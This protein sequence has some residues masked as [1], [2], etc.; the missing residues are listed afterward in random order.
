MTADT[1]VS[2]IG[3]RAT[4]VG[5]HEIML[6][7]LERAQHDKIEIDRVLLAEP[8]GRISVA[9]AARVKSPTP[10][11]RYFRRHEIS[12]L[13]YKAGKIF[14]S[15]AHMAGMT[16]R[17]IA[18]LDAEVHGG[19]GSAPGFIPASERIAEARQ[20]LRDALRAVGPALTQVTQAVLLDECPAA[21]WARKVGKPETHGFALL[22]AALDTLIGHWQ[23]GKGA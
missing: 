15:T 7:T 17:M 19:S 14:R 21:V 8:D 20:K 10:L 1:T 12:G 18:N 6:P 23:L 16:P 11:D 13:Q 3:A 2:G 5:L 9:D 22:V 4:V